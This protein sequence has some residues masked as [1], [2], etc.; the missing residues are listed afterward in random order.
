MRQVQYD[1][2]DL[3]GFMLEFV[4]Y[5]PGFREDLEAVKARLRE[6]ETVDGLHYVDL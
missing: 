2:L 3:L 5:D 4:S 6:G 1:T